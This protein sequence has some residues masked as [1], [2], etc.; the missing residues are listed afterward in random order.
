MLQKQ[1]KERRRISD[2]DKLSWV[3]FTQNRSIQ[4]RITSY[5]TNGKAWSRIDDKGVLAPGARLI[6]K[7]SGRNIKFMFGKFWI[8][9][10]LCFEDV[11]NSDSASTRKLRS[12]T[13]EK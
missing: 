4:M 5:L 10:D 1:S 6:E 11:S 7:Q 13:A 3:Q 8:G 2:K 9:A 12:F